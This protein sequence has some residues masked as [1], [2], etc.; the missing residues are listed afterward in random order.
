MYELVGEKN[1]SKSVPKTYN[2]YQNYPNPFNPVT[3]I[4]FDVPEGRGQKLEVR[5]TIYDIL[6]REVTAL[7]NDKLSPGTYEVEWSAGNYTSGIYFYRLIAD[8]FSE[9]RKMVLVK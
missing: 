9:T 5:L 4:K 3:K 6:G 2:L 7:V 1:I 8:Q